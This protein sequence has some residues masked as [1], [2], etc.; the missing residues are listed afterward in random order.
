MCAHAFSCAKKQGDIEKQ[1]FKV[2]PI[3]PPPVFSE[4]QA[5]ELNKGQPFLIHAKE[6]EQHNSEKVWSTFRHIHYK[7]H[8][9][10]NENAPIKH[11]FQNVSSLHDED[12]SNDSYKKTYFKDFL[13]YSA[14]AI[15]NFKNKVNVT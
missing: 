3:V 6:K 13:T 15:L 14:L 5:K 9:E 12:E 10:E 2:S 4:E 8:Y 11:K 7:F 1:T